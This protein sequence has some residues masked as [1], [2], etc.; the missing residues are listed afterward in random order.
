MRIGYP[1]INRSIGCSPARTFR[2]RSYS[3]SRLEETVRH[4]L[5]CLEE[6]LAYNAANGIFF[7]RITS[8]L[9]PFASHPV[10][11][12]PWQERF[13]DSFTRLG[14]YIRR[15]DMR[16]SLHPDQFTLINSPGESVFTRSVKELTYHCTILDLLE[17]DTTAKI[18]LHIGGLYNDQERSL[19]RFIRRY[20]SLDENIRSHLVI[21]NDDRLFSVSDCLRIHERTGIPVL[22]DI[23]H[24]SVLNCG[25]EMESLLRAVQKTW[26]GSDGTP[27]VDYSSQQPGRRRGVHAET[28]D[29]DHF[30]RFLTSSRPY[31][32]DIMLEIKDKEKSAL[33]A[34]AWAH[35]DSRMRLP[36]CR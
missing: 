6:I 20:D 32:I 2:L 11:T 35:S 25:E 27:M 28:I 4:N 5:E 23:F 21:E 3:D 14:E 33:Q 16:I 1:C 31:D 22:L 12:F 17:L 26:L 7:F 10:C 19:E 30:I 24:H 29:R 18:Q 36:A 8:D 13:A 9:I 34:V 15:N